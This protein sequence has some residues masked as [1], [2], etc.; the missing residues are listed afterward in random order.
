MNEDDARGDGRVDDEM[1]EEEVTSAEAAEG[2]EVPEIGREEMFDSSDLSLSV[3][4]KDSMRLE[5]VE[6]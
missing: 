2:D 3:L 6:S 1:S 5:R 4:V